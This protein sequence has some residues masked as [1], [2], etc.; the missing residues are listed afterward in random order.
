MRDEPRNDREIGTP[1][2]AMVPNDYE[3]VLLVP[4]M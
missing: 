4:V 1:C 3:S 2:Y